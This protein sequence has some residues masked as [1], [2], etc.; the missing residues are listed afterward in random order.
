M[1]PTWPG[2][3]MG[4]RRYFM[5]VEERQTRIESYGRAYDRLTAAL[6]GFPR[7]M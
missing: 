5:V 7:E 2:R 6:A 3:G 4:H 1:R